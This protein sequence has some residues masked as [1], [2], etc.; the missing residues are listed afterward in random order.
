MQTLKFACVITAVGLVLFGG[1]TSGA[2][3]WPGRGGNRR[4]LHQ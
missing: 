1:A 2:S 4:D 3:C